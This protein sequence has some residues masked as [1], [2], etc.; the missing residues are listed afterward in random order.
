MLTVQNDTGILH[1]VIAEA[2]GTALLLTAVVGSGIMGEQLAGGN[3]AIALLANS[4]TTGAILVILILIFG[5]V[6]GAHFNP[7]VTLVLGRRNGLSW[8]QILYYVIAQVLGAIGGVWIAHAMFGEPILM[9]SNHIR[10]GVPQIFGEVVATFGLL[11]TLLSCVRN[12]PRVVPVAVGLYIMA[13]YWFTSS[14]SFANPAVTLARGL[15]DTFTGIRPQD[16]PG[17]IAAQFVGALSAMFLSRFLFPNK[18]RSN[19]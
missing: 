18:D 4:L 7:A 15:T 2:I 1:K 3:V 9:I 10:E 8:S 5:E 13:A 6:S 19:R 14:T 12:H 16:I 17:F 11:L